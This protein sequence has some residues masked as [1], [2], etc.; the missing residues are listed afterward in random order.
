[1][2]AEVIDFPAVHDAPL[3]APPPSDVLAIEAAKQISLINGARHPGAV[4]GLTHRHYN[5]PARFSPTLV[6]EAINI[7]TRPGDLVLDPYVG[8]GT[9]LVEAY[10]RGRSAIGSDISTLAKFVSETKL[11]T[12][13]RTDAVGFLASVSEVVEEIN[14]RRPEPA[15]DDWAEL[16]YFRNLGSP[17]RWRLRKAISQAVAAIEKIDDR[18]VESLARCALLR[19]AHWALDGRKVLPSIQ[20][21]RKSFKANAALIADGARALHSATSEHK[22]LRPVVLNRSIIGLDTDPE[23]FSSKPPRLIVTS[24]PYPGVHVLYHRW[25]V[26]GRK[27]SPA[28][29]FIANALDGSGEAYYTMG[30]RKGAELPTYFEQLEAG[31]SSLAAIADGDTILVQV[32]AFAKPEWQLPRYL[33][34]ASCAGWEEFSL[35]LL[36]GEADGRLWRAVPNRKWHANR[37]GLTGGAREVVLFHRLARR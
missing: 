3:H 5:Y 21:F 15:F 26:D 31:L 25:Q 29:F 36:Q 16:G 6:G 34:V 8:G 17:K 19:T 14:I 18:D 37:K 22:A 11:I 10:A 27:E 2:R 1:V 32:V 4:V 23:I 33:E 24:P 30:G 13:T 20:D 9:T 35:S 12:L 7:F 28:P